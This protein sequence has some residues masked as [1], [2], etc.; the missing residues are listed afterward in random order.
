MRILWHI[1]VI[2]NCTSCSA[3]IP[4]GQKPIDQSGLA[5]ADGLRSDI[6]RRRWDRAQEAGEDNIVAVEL[7]VEVACHLRLGGDDVV[8]G[9]HGTQ[10][11]YSHK[12]SKQQSALIIPLCSYST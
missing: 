8:V 2:E 1:A 4:I 5:V 10:Q 11:L 6:A 7:C 12:K 3:F 9:G